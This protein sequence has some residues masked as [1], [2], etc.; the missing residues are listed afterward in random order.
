MRGALSR[1]L[2]A[3]ACA[4]LFVVAFAAGFW[5][6]APWDELG[7][8]AFNEGSLLAAERGYYVT[9]DSVTCSGAW[10]PVYSISGLNVEGPFLSASF[11]DAAVTFHP[12]RSL[13][14]AGP[15]FSLAF[16]K[17]EVSYVVPSKGSF[18]VSSG[19]LYVEAGGGEA[20]ARDIDIRGDFSMSG[21][22]TVDMPRRAITRS[23]AVMT[24]PAVFNAAFGAFGS[25]VFGKYLAPDGASRWRIKA[26]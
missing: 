3:L 24:V 14:A 21:D 5:A 16:G 12:L 9:C 25:G 6:L 4:A 1:V 22:L 18:A 8:F 11:A 23:T 17:T 15:A 26:Q 10:P 7:G 20:R 13:L 19:A 2:R